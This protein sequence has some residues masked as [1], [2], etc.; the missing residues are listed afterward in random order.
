MN[1]QQLAASVR[2]DVSRQRGN[3]VLARIFGPEQPVPLAPRQIQTPERR[4][5]SAVLTDA[6]ER[7][8]LL[9]G[10]RRRNSDDQANELV[11]LRAWSRDGDLSWPYSLASVCDLLE[12]DFAAVGAALRKTLDGTLSLPATKRIHIGGVALPLGHARKRRAKIVALAA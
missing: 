12:L 5:V 4:L 10:R 8:R 2:L 3:D 9:S 6:F 11:E 1:Q 7:A